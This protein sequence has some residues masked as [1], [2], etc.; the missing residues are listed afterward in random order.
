MVSVGKLLFLTC[1]ICFFPFTTPE[2]IIVKTSSGLVRGTEVIAFPSNES[3]IA[4]LGIKIAED[5][6]GVNRFKKA[7]P[8][9]P[10]S[11]IWNATEYGVACVA[12]PPLTYKT[13]DGGPIGEDCLWTNVFTS[14]YCLLKK[15]CPV[16]A[17]VHGGNYNFESPVIFP[18]ETVANNFVAQGRNIV[19]VVVPFRVGSFGGFNLSPG[20]KSSADRNLNLQDIHFNLKWIQKEVANF[21]GDP[22]RVTL[23]GHSSGA[24]L[25]EWISLSPKFVGFFHQ[26]IMMS[27]SKAMFGADISKRINEK[28]SIAVAKHVKCFNPFP[29]NGKVMSLRGSTE[30]TE[31]NVEAILD[32]MRNKTYQDI[33]AAQVALYDQTEDFHGPG[34]DG[35]HGYIPDYA[36]HLKRTKRRTL[37][38][39]TSAESKSGGFMMGHPA[40]LKETCTHLGFEMKFEDPILFSKRCFE[41]Y[42]KHRTPIEFFDDLAFYASTAKIADDLVDVGSE[43]YMYSYEYQDTGMAFKNLTNEQ[44]PR[45]RR[46]THSEDYIYV[47]GIHRGPFTPKDWENERVYSGIVA[48]FIKGKDLSRHYRPWKPWDRDRNYLRINFDRDYKIQK[49]KVGYKYYQDVSDFWNERVTTKHLP[50]KT[51]PPSFDTFWAENLMTALESYYFN[52]TTAHDKTMAAEMRIYKEWTEYLTQAAL[53]FEKA[54]KLAKFNFHS[55]AQPQFNG[56]IWEEVAGTLPVLA[57][58]I[59][60]T[61]TIIGLYVLIKCL[62]DGFVMSRTPAKPAE[63]PLLSYEYLN[64]PPPPS[65]SSCVEN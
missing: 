40:R 62:W 51:Y 61:L 64:M 56:F 7:I 10:W 53:E 8:V 30:I 39:T 5:T 21:G 17:V 45:E 42:S 18:K 14:K 46:P 19:A 60:G 1:F 32:C 37:I 41:Q 31:E 48:D 22:S 13:D 58:V 43:V 12:D 54:Q 24:T 38:G 15:N 2:E 20:I 26:T 47:M 29:N 44:F 55:A 16:V 50:L 63:Q 49:A 52:V 28:A 59:F 9:K 34:I 6:G 33:L 27:P 57:V 4:F 23:M 3:T 36:N 35:R 11:R 65:Y 25:V